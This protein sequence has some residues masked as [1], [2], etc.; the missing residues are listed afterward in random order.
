MLPG[1]LLGMT[2]AIGMAAR[3]MNAAQQA[4]QANYSAAMQAM[5]GQANAGFQ[6]ALTNAK[7]ASVAL[8]PR[9]YAA[10][11]VE[12]DRERRYRIEMEKWDAI[13]DSARAAVAEGS[14][15]WRQSIG[16]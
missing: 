8:P 13:A 15:R 6:S 5:Q 10:L 7:G 1:S 16:V 3:D 11:V 4:A 9:T 12:S 2:G 14:A